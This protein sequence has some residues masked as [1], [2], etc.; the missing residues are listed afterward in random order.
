MTVIEA[1]DIKGRRVLMTSGA[2]LPI[3]AL[4]DAWNEPVEDPMDATVFVAGN[5]ELWTAA[6]I[7]AMPWPT[8]H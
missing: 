2:V 4:L 3:T 1:I 6:A 7:C 5:N 8:V